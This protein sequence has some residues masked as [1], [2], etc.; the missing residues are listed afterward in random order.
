[1]DLDAVTADL[2]DRDDVRE[3]TALGFSSAETLAGKQVFTIIAA[4]GGT[5][6]F[7]VVTGRAPVGRDE[8]AVGLRTAH[9]LHLRVGDTVAL[10]GD[11]VEPRQ[12]TVAGIVVLPALGPFQADRGGPGTGL[13][14]PAA[15]V[16]PNAL[17][18]Y[19]AFVGLDLVPGVSPHAALERLSGDVAKWE[20]IQGP[21]IPPARALSAPVRP[22]E[23]FN[24]QAVR[25]VPFLAGVLLA[26]ATIVGLGFA[27]V[28]SVRARGR[29]LATLRALGFTPAQL[30][31]SVTLQAVATMVAAL[32]LAI[33]LG[34]VLGRVAWST[35]A[36]QLGVA[37]DPS[38]PS[39]AL[40]VLA[41]L[42]LV[43]AAVASVPAQ[44]VA[45]RQRGPVHQD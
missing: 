29:E 30:R 37:G 7:P 5:T 10:A 44:V 45:V 40:V 12:V 8:V 34:L 20:T 42:A 35:F 39:I 1:M 41:V 36:T 3:W 11:D 9:D 15:A 22:P 17:A 13:L 4:G 14:L 21:D 27:L 25:S 43:L 18:T 26:A 2:G 6:A 31:R 33:P 19:M 28:V 24:A 23:I 32:V 38:I 16:D